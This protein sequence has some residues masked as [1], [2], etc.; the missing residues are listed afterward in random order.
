MMQPKIPTIVSHNSGKIATKSRKS[1]QH[2]LIINWVSP[3][4]ITLSTHLF[5]L[6]RTLT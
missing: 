4:D 2:L 6:N 3:F 5:L 1:S